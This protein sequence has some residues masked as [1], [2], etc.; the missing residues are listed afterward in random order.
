MNL[1]IGI[2]SLCFILSGCN[3]FGWLDAPSG[4]TQLLE[5]A[6]SCLD[7][8]D[9]VCARDYYSQ[10]SAS[11]ADTVEAEEAY[12]ALDE[13]GVSIRVLA[14]AFFSGSFG[15]PG[16]TVLANQI[17][18][19]GETKRNAIHA[20]YLKHLNMT[21]G[22]E[23]EFVRFITG[24][25]LA[26]ELLAE[27]KGAVST[28]DLETDDLA[29]TPSTCMAAGLCTVEA[30]CDPPAAIAFR[31]TA[32][33]FTAVD[34]SGLADLT[35]GDGKPTYAMLNDTLDETVTALTALGASGGFSSG[36]TDFSDIGT[37]FGT[38]GALGSDTERARCYT[39]GLLNN[40]I[41]TTP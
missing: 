32:P 20:A 37:V 35:T 40:G 41:A 39:Q 28:S 7:R 30:T 6:R 21:A 25:A 19:A 4:D 27:S 18:S 17:S 10:V 29:T 26:A 36:G 5:A 38:L 9:F 23:R 34:I 15:T 24:L 33:S 12:L 11:F 3:V 1:K 2:F 22:S 8:G 16:L 31:Q 14:Q 13:Q